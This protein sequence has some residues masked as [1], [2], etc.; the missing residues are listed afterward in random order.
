MRLLPK[1][2]EASLRLSAGLVVAGLLVALPTLFWTHAISFLLFL[3]LAAMLV[4][5]GVL[6]YLLALLRFTRAMEPGH[7]DAAR[8]PGA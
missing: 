1:S 2:F 3:G 7:T 6:V 4:A 5:L 8:D